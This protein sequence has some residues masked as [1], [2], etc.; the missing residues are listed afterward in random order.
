M[1]AEFAFGTTFAVLGLATK[2]GYVRKTAFPS[3]KQRS[4][5]KHVTLT[6]REALEGA[7]RPLC[8][9]ELT[10]KENFSWYKARNMQTESDGTVF[11]IENA[12]SDDGRQVWLHKTRLA[13]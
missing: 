5:G 3:C 1:S 10:K 8:G 2:Q 12:L 6:A 11:K 7:I 4:A 13:N 9:A